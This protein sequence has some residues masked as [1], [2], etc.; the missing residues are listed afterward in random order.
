MP[1]SVEQEQLPKVDLVFPLAGQ[2]VPTDHGYALFGAL[3]RV[4]GDLHGA[5]WLAVHPIAGIA[6]AGGTLALYDRRGA[7]RLRVLP[8]EIPRVLPLAGKELDLD[9]HRLLVGVSRVVA[10]EPAPAL[11]ARTVVIKGFMEP[12]PFVAAVERQL[13]DL[14]VKARVTLGR[15]RVVTINGDKVVGFETLLHDLSPDDSLRVQYA[16]IGG[17]QRMGC[18]VFV[19]QRAGQRGE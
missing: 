11:R 4:L 6:R 1:K 8:A 9:G 7:L 16:G 14:G 15:R 5:D 3:C 12:E 2:T 17:R 13:Q 10:I 19:A 18:G